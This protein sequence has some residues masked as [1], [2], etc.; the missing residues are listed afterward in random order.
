MIL[1]EY[2]QENSHPMIDY[3]PHAVCQGKYY[4]NSITINPQNFRIYINKKFNSLQCFVGIDDLYVKDNSGDCS[5]FNFLIFADGICV[6]CISNFFPGDSPFFINLNIKDVEYLDFVIENKGMRN[7]KVSWMDVNLLEDTTTHVAALLGDI[8]IVV[9]ENIKKCNRCLITV[10]TPNFV[11]SLDLMLKSFYL[12]SGCNDCEVLVYVF[13]ECEEYLEIQKKYNVNLIKCSSTNNSTY[14]IKVV[15]LSAPYIILA[16]KYL[17]ID[18]DCLI[19]EDLNPLFSVLNI[20]NEDKIF[21][22][23][24]GSV[25]E[26][27]ILGN[28]LF[29]ANSIYYGEE[30]E[31]KLLNLT[32]RDINNNFVI[33]NGVYAARRRAL[34]SLSN[35]IKK[36]LLPHGLLWEKNKIKEGCLWREQG[37]MN[38][39]ISKLDNAVEMSNLYNLQLHS[40]DIDFDIKNFKTTFSGQP[41]KIL[42]FNGS[43]R[44]K[45]SDIVD[46]FI[47]FDF[48]Q[49]NM[50]YFKKLINCYFGKEV[51]ENNLSILN[52]IYNLISCNKISNIL[53][54]DNDDCFVSI[55]AALSN[56]ENKITSIVKNKNDKFSSSISVSNINYEK[57]D[58]LVFLNNI[59]YCFDYDLVIINNYSSCYDLLSMFKII[60]NIGQNKF[61]LLINNINEEYFAEFIKKVKKE[62]VYFAP[63]NYNKSDQN[64]D[65]LLFNI[66]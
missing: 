13:G 27:H 2:I 10:S 50:D 36:T 38:I 6:E 11:D 20:F 64:I 4:P 33:N 48:K 62:K 39:G 49:N 16:D 59:E 65:Y 37:L 15:G 44:N 32:N 25:P 41:V 61:L 24:E 30:S 29:D 12:N 31:K 42:H 66:N 52:I 51:F 26:G 58:F 45:Y 63:C 21:I 7:C 5:Y 43:G 47:S 57:S 18:A 60:S 35:I 54:L 46:L 40:Y 23:K 9:P 19:L 55:C 17:F 1:S 3:F 56:H 14:K 34:L 28:I 53:T 8:D 22:S